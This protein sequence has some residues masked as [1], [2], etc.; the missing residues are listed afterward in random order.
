MLNST[1]YSTLKENSNLSD[2]LLSIK[3]TLTNNKKTLLNNLITNRLYLNKNTHKDIKRKYLKTFKILGQYSLWL[4][5]RAWILKKFRRFQITIPDKIRLKQN[6]NIEV[7]GRVYA[8]TIIGKE[9]L[10]SPKFRK[11]KPVAFTYRINRFIKHFFNN[12]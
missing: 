7:N 11:G 12:N 3:L 4:K 2:D 1:L 8:S 10:F 5:K 9:F 6:V